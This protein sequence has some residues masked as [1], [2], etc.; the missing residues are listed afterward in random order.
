MIHGRQ[1]Q[2]RSTEDTRD[3]GL[4]CCSVASLTS[5]C[6]GGA[7]RCTTFPP[8]RSHGTNTL[9]KENLAVHH[10]LR[11]DSILARACK[12]A[13]AEGQRGKATERE[14]RVCDKR[15]GGNRVVAFEAFSSS[16]FFFFL[17]FSFLS[18]FLLLSVVRYPGGGGGQQGAG[19][20]R[21]DNYKQQEQGDYEKGLGHRDAVTSAVRLARLPTEPKD[22]SAQNALNTPNTIY[23]PNEPNRV[24][25]CAQTAFQA[26][27]HQSRLLYLKSLK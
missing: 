3:N 20:Q 7:Y 4:S 25:L 8:P 16:S 11:V 15:E 17:S 5:T 26:L 2:S 21:N 27:K 18:F 24:S 6:C 14:R 1:I 19:Q 10:P 22:Y 9:G 12:S 13:A 23:M